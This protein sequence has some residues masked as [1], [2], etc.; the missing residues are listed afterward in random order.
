[1]SRRTAI[2]LSLDKHSMIRG[3]TAT[4]ISDETK[5]E[6]PSLEMHTDLDFYGQVLNNI[7]H[8]EIKSDVARNAHAD[9]RV[10]GFS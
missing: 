6:I 7:C 9:Q 10:F 1:M 8:E 4:N 2:V 5:P 3:F